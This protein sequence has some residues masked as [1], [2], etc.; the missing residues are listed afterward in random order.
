MALRKK[1]LLYFLNQSLVIFA[2][3]TFSKMNEALC[4]VVLWGS[5][6]CYEWNTTLRSALET[7]PL[8]SL[9]VLPAFQC[10]IDKNTIT[11]MRN[12]IYYYSSS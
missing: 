5:G 12:S 10:K 1:K 9:A 11:R 7:C 8:G 4:T 6:C 3:F 2:F